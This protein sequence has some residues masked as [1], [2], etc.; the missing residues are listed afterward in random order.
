MVYFSNFGETYTDNV[1]LHKGDYTVVVP[2]E[3]YEKQSG[4]SAIIYPNYLSVDK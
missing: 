4:K 1:W 2:C 3:C